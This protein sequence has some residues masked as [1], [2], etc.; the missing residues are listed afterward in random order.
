MCISA[1]VIKRIVIF[2]IVLGFLGQACLL[3]L[4]INDKIYPQVEEMARVEAANAATQIIKRSVSTIEVNPSECMSFLR[5]E[6]GNIIEV[7]YNTYTMN[8]ILSECLHVAETSLDAASS[9]QMD[10]NT[11]MICYDKGVIYSVNLGYFTGIALFS[12]IGPQVDIH[13]EVMNSCSGE[14]EVNS[15]PYGI[16]STLIQIDLIITTQ[17]LVV[18]PFL[19][20]QAPIECRIPLVIQIVQGK[21]PDYIMD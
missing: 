8:Q 17:L 3:V 12:R 16:N 19:M 15:S 10:P 4:R 2:F 13:M 6:E 1:K 9:G 21:L 20:T 14:I 7:N 11:K 5:D 18:T